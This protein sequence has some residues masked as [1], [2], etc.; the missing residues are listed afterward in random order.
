ML[1]TH[2]LKSIM[3]KEVNELKKKVFYEMLNLAGRV[4]IL[5]RP[6]DNVVIGKRGFTEDEKKNGLILVFNSRMNFLWDEDGISAT[7]VFGTTPEKCFIPSD[8]IVFIFSP[9]LHSQFS[10]SPEPAEK[11]K[12][13]EE[14]RI[15]S[16]DNKAKPVKEDRIVKVDFT[17]KRR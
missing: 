12:G 3:Q 11:V 14:K 10:V 13:E 16:E 6:S 9:E 15:A 5:V 7:L 17:K 8:D 2:M 1:V 4:F